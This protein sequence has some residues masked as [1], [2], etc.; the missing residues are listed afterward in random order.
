MYH[1]VVITLRELS[2]YTD[3]MMIVIV[4]GTLTFKKGLDKLFLIYH[5]LLSSPNLKKTYM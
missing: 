4:R 5:N 1:N 2:P 3:A